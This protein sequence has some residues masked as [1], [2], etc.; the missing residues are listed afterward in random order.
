MALYVDKTCCT[1]QIIKYW[2]TCPPYSNPEM[3]AQSPMFIYLLTGVIS[4]LKTVG[5]IYE[6]LEDVVDNRNPQLVREKKIE[7]KSTFHIDNMS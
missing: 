7:R 1:F 2:G 6:H 3:D 5:S 4:S